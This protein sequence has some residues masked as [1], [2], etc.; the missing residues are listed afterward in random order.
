MVLNESGICMNQIFR[1]LAAPNR[2]GLVATIFAIAL[3]FTPP[4]V[5][6][7]LDDAISRARDLVEEA[8]QEQGFPGLSVAVSVDGETIWAEGFGYSDIQ[9]ELPISTTSMFRI[10][11]ISKPFTA[12]AIARLF[13]EGRLDVDAP[14]QEYVPGFPEKRWTITTRQLGGHLAGIRHYRGNEM[15]STVHYPTVESGLAIFS[16]D[17]L[18]HEPGSKYLY[19]SYGWNLISAV[20]EGASGTAFLEYMNETVFAPLGMDNTVAD[21]ATEEMENRVGFYVRDEDGSPV[22]APHVDNSYKWAGGGF[23]STPLDIVKFANA[24]LDDSFLGASARALLFTPQELS[25]GSKTTY[26]FGWTAREDGKGR[27]ILGH[28]GGSIGG[29]SILQMNATYDLVVALTINLSSA[30]LAIGRSLTQL[31]LDELEGDTR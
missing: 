2:P 14:I 13:E 24:H 19:S 3:V 15:M 28:T 17:P 21:M 12:A 16:A 7:N 27:L 26:G 9:S 8:M 5:A 18:L 22:S 29:T 31:F 25:D 20:V 6:Q 11:S 1:I 30:D 23:L 4:V 10:G